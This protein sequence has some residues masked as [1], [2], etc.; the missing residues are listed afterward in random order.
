[1]EVLWQVLK[2]YKILDKVGYC[3]GDNY[4]SNDKLLQ[5]LFKRLQEAEI[6]PQYNPQQHCIC[7]HGHVLNIAAQ[8]F[9]FLEDKEA[10]DAVFKDACKKLKAESDLKDN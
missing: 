1:M 6:E 8:A 10:I 5:G 2:D 4:G 9:F 7:C 3:V